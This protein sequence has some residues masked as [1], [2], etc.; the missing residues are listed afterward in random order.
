MAKTLKSTPEVTSETKKDPSMKT[1]SV[2]TINGGIGKNIAAT[3]VVKAIKREYPDTK[4]VI[5]T[6]WAEVWNNN[7]N[8]YRVYRHNNTPY[9]YSDYVQGKDVN[10]FCLEPY[11][12]DEYLLKENHLIDIW[13][14]LCGVERKGEMPELIINEREKIFFTVKYGNAP[15]V[16]IQT[17]GGAENQTYK[18]SWM[19]DMPMG[20]AQK[21]V[22]EYNTRGQY[23]VFH[24]RRDDQPALNNVAQIS[25][26]SIRELFWLVGNAANNVIIDSFAQHAAAALGAKADVFWIGNSPKVLGYPAHNNIVSKAAFEYENTRD[27]PFEPYDISGAIEQYPFKDGIDNIFDEQ[28]VF[29]AIFMKPDDITIEEVKTE[30]NAPANDIIDPKA[31]TKKIKA[32][33]EPKAE[34]EVNPVADESIT[35]PEVNPDVKEEVAA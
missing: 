17:N 9:F 15:Y 8:V 26:P 14:K 25:A 20:I 11:S 22:D 24:I 23:R 35:P 33:A 18:Y 21:I 3:A 19:R 16:I 7:E 5:V 29:K 6:G 28:E 12:T 1:F 32:K 2:L 34:P 10:M 4:I 31:E 13:C 30:N 27:Y